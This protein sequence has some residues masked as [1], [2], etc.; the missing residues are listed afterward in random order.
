MSTSEKQAMDFWFEFDDFFLFNFTE[1]IRGAIF[2]DIIPFDLQNG[3]VTHQQNGTLNTDFK[4][5]LNKPELQQLRDSIKLVA[6][7]HLRIQNEFFANNVALEQAAFEYFGQGSLFD[8]GMGQDGKPRRQLARRI[9]MMDGGIGGYLLWYSFIRSVMILGFS[10]DSNRWLQTVRH[11][12]L[13]AA[14][15]SVVGPKQSENPPGEDPRIRD[16]TANRIDP[17]ALSPLRAEWLTKSV[18][19]I[20]SK[21]I[22][23][24]VV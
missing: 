3:F 15:D 22:E 7:N 19:Q 10:G 6:D 1:N 16:H 17:A 2:D 24:D 4:R 13:S 23:L 20:D 21:I 5:E 14:I 12:A 8:D 9:H 18:D 11:I